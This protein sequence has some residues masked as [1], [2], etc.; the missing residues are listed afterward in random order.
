MET[1]NQVIIQYVTQIVDFALYCECGMYNP[2][3]D[4]IRAADLS[5]AAMTQLGLTKP[6][7]DAVLNNNKSTTKNEH[8]NDQIEIKWIKTN[9]FS[10]FTAH[11]STKELSRDALM[12]VLPSMFLSFDSAHHFAHIP[13]KTRL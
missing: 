5:L 10:R 12:F 8:K 13:P 3:V 2:D 4:P 1:D 9:G 11:N 7:N 6:N